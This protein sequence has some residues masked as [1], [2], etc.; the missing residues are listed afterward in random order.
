[1]N[2]NQLLDTIPR[3]RFGRA[4][5][6]V[7][8]F[9]TCGVVGYY[10]AVLVAMGGGLLAGVSL[11]VMAVV[12]LVCAASFFVYVY[13]RRWLTGRE[14]LE[15][16]DQVWF[17]ELCTAGALLAIGVPLLPYLDV[18]AV[19]LCPFLAA[20]RVGCTLVGCCHGRPS[21]IGFVYG[22]EHVR[23]GFPG[24]LAGVRLF[25][26]PALE[27]AG[28]ALIGLSGLLALPF[29]PA[30]HVFAW[31]L[32]AYAVLRFGLEWL[33][34][35]VRLQWLGL[36]KPQWMAL[37]EFGIGLW[38]AG[39]AGSGFQLG[40]VLLVGVLVAA[41]VV[42]LVARRT[43]ELR[44][45]LLASVHLR[46]LWEATAAPA[47]PNGVGLPVVPLRATSLGV[48]LGVSP[49]DSE[50]DAVL[51]VSLSLPEGRR[52]LALLCELAAHAF[53]RLLPEAGRASAAGVLH[54]R[55]PAG[56]APDVDLEAA[57]RLG[58]ALFGAVA[59]AL[60]APIEEPSAAPPPGGIEPRRGYFGEVWVGGV[61]RGS[62][63]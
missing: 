58:R 52:D 19:A 37:V 10:L 22:E 18:L 16:L 57:E 9:R 23:D 33:R 63:G 14:T 38:I 40:D 24:Y 53:P 32:I 20:G 49:A 5:R 4:T 15:L 43:F 26:V 56:P 59:R 54:L 8:A 28:L 51:H 1:M 44:P 36:S 29:A 12:A 7:P 25:P 60:Q 17:A 35:D 21:S 27:A 50:Y 48:S 46:E 45:R 61:T 55:V 6:E 31:F 11:L 34:G 3:T 47:G 62:S 41:L 42:A 2:L 13:V 39:G 30:G